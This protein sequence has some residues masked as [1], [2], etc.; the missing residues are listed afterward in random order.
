MLQN[1]NGKCKWNSNDQDNKQDHQCGTEGRAL[2]TGTVNGLVQGPSH[3]GNNRGPQHRHNKVFEHM[4][5]QKHQDKKQS[6]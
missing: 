2:T 4:K 5:A 6:K 1:K 3:I